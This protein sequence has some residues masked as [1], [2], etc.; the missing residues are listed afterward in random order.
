MQAT[1]FIT[2]WST[3]P[4]LDAKMICIFQN[5]DRRLISST[6]MYWRQ[7]KFKVGGDLLSYVV[8]G[9][10]PLKIFGFLTLFKYFNFLNNNSGLQ[11]YFKFV[12]KS[13]NIKVDQRA[14]PAVDHQISFMTL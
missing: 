7:T 13:H 4:K 6:S 3:L 2:N 9:L 10:I 5:L 12:R 11:S 1:C 8:S 14:H